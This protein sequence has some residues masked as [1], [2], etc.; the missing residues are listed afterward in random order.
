MSYFKYILIIL[1]VSVFLIS[2]CEK[3]D[4]PKGT[5]KVTFNNNN[6]IKSNLDT[7][8]ISSKIK[9]PFRESIESSGHFY[10][11]N[12]KGIRSSTLNNI[13]NS[14]TSFTIN[15]IIANL[16]SDSTY[17]ITPF[18]KFEGRSYI[19]EGEAV[20]FTPRFPVI[21]VSEFINTSHNSTYLVLDKSIPDGIDLLKTG[22]C[23][24]TISNP[25][26]SNFVVELGAKDTLSLD[27]FKT[28]KTYFFRSFASI[29]TGIIYG[30]EKSLVFIF[31]KPTIILKE[32]SE[33]TGTKSKLTAE[34]TSDGG[35]EITEKG[36]IWG[37]DKNLDDTDNIIK[38]TNNESIIYTTLN[39]LTENKL[40]YFKSFATN[41]VGTEYSDVK[42]FNTAISLA[43]VEITDTSYLKHNKCTFNLNIKTTGGTNISRKGICYSLNENPTID[44]NYIDSENSNHQFSIIVQNLSPNTSYN[45]RA[46]AINEKGVA[47]SEN[48]PIKTLITSGS[49]I[50]KEFQNLQHNSVDI[51]SKVTSD[52]GGI[53]QN[54]GVDFTKD[55]EFKSNISEIRSKTLGYEDNILTIGSLEPNTVY[56]CRAFLITNF[57]RVESSIVEIKTPYDF[58]DI[59]TVEISDISYNSLEIKCK[60][61][62]YGGGN[63]S[64]Y[65]I[66]WSDDLSSL[67]KKAGSGINNNGEF[68]VSLTNLNSKTKY[69]VAAY[70]NNE[71]GES[72]GDTLNYTTKHL[73]PT[74]ETVQTKDIT[75]SAIKVEYKIVEQ[76]ISPIVSAGICYNTSENPVIEDNFESGAVNISGNEQVTIE[77]LNENQQYY[78]RSYVYTENDT[79]YG[80][81]LTATTESLNLVTIE[82]GTFNMGYNKGN[83]DYTEHNVTLSNFKISKYETTNADYCKFMNSID[84]SSQG[85]YSGTGENNGE[86]FIKVPISEIMYDSDNN[87][88]IPKTG[89]ENH[90]VVYVTWIGASAYCK[91]VGGRLPTEAEWEYAAKG[92]KNL[93]DTF[94]SGSDDPAAVANYN[95]LTGTSAVNSNARSSNNLGLYDMSGNVYEWCYDWYDTNYYNVSPTN[96]PQGPDSGTSKVRRGGSWNSS[97]SDLYTNI[98]EG[99]NIGTPDVYT[100]FRVAYN[101]D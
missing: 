25:D 41:S 11:I 31:T 17:H 43:K 52:G 76:G 65:G 96:N 8:F 68:T 40:Y 95:S 53:I 100:G 18:F 99:L 69:F 16:Q 29:N 32:A 67:S 39:N 91:W 60:I 55:P 2:G 61:N 13:S 66:Y 63:L 10:S 64:E 80:N 62:D 74:I 94:Y 86:L 3:A 4:I 85:I 92:G 56:Y 24:D 93:S 57:S 90:P 7:I 77:N 78:F 44:D 5:S 79:V 75:P 38:L 51:V 26:T 28:G 30:K 84:I 89:K 9:N 36:F 1:T 54:I 6:T 14:D 20:V 45:F 59:S 97:V 101:A 34:I 33:I 58:I 27:N 12:S 48:L 23:Y 19:H 46:F 47:Y 35:K 73:Y 70:A 21:Q 88:F 15:S 87:I 71:K 50:I 82:G 42:S 98:R 49:I 72:R 81:Q 37:E 22:I 83:S